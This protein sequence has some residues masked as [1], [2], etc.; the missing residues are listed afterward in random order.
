MLTFT[1]I[2]SESVPLLVHS[3]S[4]KRRCSPCHFLLIHSREAVLVLLW[5]LIIGIAS[6]VASTA[7]SVDLVHTRMIEL[8]LFLC[9]I[10]AGYLGDFLIS[11]H[12]LILAGL[13]SLFL[14]VILMLLMVSL[15]LVPSTTGCP[16][17]IIYI[18]FSYAVFF[19]TF[20][21]RVNLLPFNIEQLIGSSSDELTAIIHWHN[22]GPLLGSFII[23]NVN[24]LATEYQ[25]IVWLGSI[26]VCVTAVLVSHSLF[27]GILETTPVNTVNPVKLIV[28]VLCYARKHKYPEN[29][30]ALTYWEEEAPSRLDLGKDKYG[31]PFTEE[32]VEDVKTVLR[33]VPLVIIFGLSVG[34]YGLYTISMDAT[35]Y[36]CHGLTTG[37][38]VEF[39]GYVFLIVFMLFIL[40]QSYFRK[41]IPSLLKRIGIGLVLIFIGNILCT[42]LAFIGNYKFGETFHCLTV[43]DK[44]IFATMK[45]QNWHYFDVIVQTILWYTNNVASVEF[46]LAQC[47]KSMR[48]TMIGLWLCLRNLRRDFQFMLIFWPF[49]QYMSPDILLGRGF[50][51]LLTVSLVSL[52]VLVLFIYLAKR[53]KLRVREVEI[54]I[55]QI[56]EN[57]TIRYIEQDEEHRINYSSSS[58]DNEEV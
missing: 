6:F 29:R 44:K 27:N 41:Y 54:N 24:S 18:I 19:I 15:Q 30:S 7:V 58:S 48:G 53:Y 21:I 49:L 56:A 14:L 9:F 57:H 43:F 22:A 23:F 38:Y 52:L 2:M 16:L 5:D 17:M 32:E 11:R 31:G 46:I 55:H 35:S 8:G 47:P 12:K 13:Y 25:Y 51:F 36:G 1:I 33:L 26:I 50:Y 37:M 42:G 45:P 28:R 39:T 40:K 3:S 10:V 4:V 34:L 20:A